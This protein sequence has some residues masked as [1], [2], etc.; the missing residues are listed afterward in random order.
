M[1]I[2]SIY[3]NAKW[4]NVVK[5]AVPSR[6]CFVPTFTHVPHQGSEGRQWTASWLWF[7]VLRCANFSSGTSLDQRLNGLCSCLNDV[8]MWHHC[9]GHVRCTYKISYSGIWIVVDSGCHCGYVRCSEPLYSF[10]APGFD[11]SP[12]L[13]IFNSEA[14]LPRGRQMAEGQDQLF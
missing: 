1:S 4:C 7:R 9:I 10:N 14:W 13:L 5:D 12:S 11:P 2:Y 8:S 3:A 6:V